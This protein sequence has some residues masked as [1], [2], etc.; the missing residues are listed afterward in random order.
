LPSSDLR[1]ENVNLVNYK[2]VVIRVKKL[3]LYFIE[4]ILESVAQRLGQKKVESIALVLHSSAS[5]IHLTGKD[6]K[7]I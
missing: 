4:F 6:D 3:H 1:F 2:K 7:V 5:A